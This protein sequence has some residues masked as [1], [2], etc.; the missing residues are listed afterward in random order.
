[1][2]QNAWQAIPFIPTHKGLPEQ[3]PSPSCNDFRS[4]ATAPLL[5][6]TEPFGICT[7]HYVMII[8]HPTAQPKATG[9]SATTVNVT[10][11][12]AWLDSARTSWDQ[13]SLADSVTAD[14]QLAALCM[15]GA[16]YVNSSDAGEADAI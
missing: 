4:S 11:K 3:D 12:T 6:I 1:M 15:P 8:C 10:S 7:A 2:T 13:N 16:M 9:C 14:H 5:C